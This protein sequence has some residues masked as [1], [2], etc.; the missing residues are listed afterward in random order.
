MQFIGADADFRA[1]PKLAA[2]GKAGRGIP[3]NRRGIDLAQ[4]PLG[5]LLI[6]GNDAVAMVRTV[7]LDVFDSLVRRIKRLHR[8]DEIEIL[9]GPVFLGRAL[10]LLVA[11]S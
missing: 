2:I 7:A 4:E 6:A 5:Q 9:G 8:E 11:E 3:I 1:K 10:Q